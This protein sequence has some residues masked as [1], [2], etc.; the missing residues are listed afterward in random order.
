MSTEFRKN[1]KKEKK[2]M[3]TAVAIEPSNTVP[4]VVS[5]V[6]EIP[7]QHIRESKTNPRR[8]FDEAKLAELAGFVPRNRTGVMLQPAFCVRRLGTTVP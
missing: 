3:N 2:R 7:L 1:Q 6:Q 4:P 5:S 8:Q